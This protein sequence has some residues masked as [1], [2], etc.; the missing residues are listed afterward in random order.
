[1]SALGSRL[2]CV[3]LWGAI[4]HTREHR[5]KMGFEGKLKS[6]ILDLFSWE[7]LTSMQGVVQARITHS[8]CSHRMSEAVATG[9]SLELFTKTEEDQ[10][11]QES[12]EK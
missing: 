12:W 5:W 10:R 4:Y 9:G 1:M 8:T 2:K 6:M 7:S 3:V 11:G